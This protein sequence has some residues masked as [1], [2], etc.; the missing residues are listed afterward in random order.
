MHSKREQFKNRVKCGPFNGTFLHQVGDGTSKLGRK[1]KKRDQGSSARPLADAL[2]G[3][4]LLRC[5]QQHTS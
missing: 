4:K 2:R 5:H 1:I 3:I